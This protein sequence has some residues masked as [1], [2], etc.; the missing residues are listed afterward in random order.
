MPVA[1]TGNRTV[2]TK[3]SA[4]RDAHADPAETQFTVDASMGSDGVVRLTLPADHM[5]KVGRYAYR[6]DFHDGDRV[7]P[8]LRGTLTIE[9]S[10]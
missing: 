6:I 3:L 5:N 7:Q 8:L 1:L 10:V 4:S 2:V 9:E